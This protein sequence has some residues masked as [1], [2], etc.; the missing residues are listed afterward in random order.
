M[1]ARFHQSGS[2]ALPGCCARR[3]RTLRHAGWHIVTTPCSRAF[4]TGSHHTGPLTLKGRRDMLT[5]AILDSE[6]YACRA[7]ICT[8]RSNVSEVFRVSRCFHSITPS[9]IRTSDTRFRK[10][11]LWGVN[12]AQVIDI[13]LHRKSAQFRPIGVFGHSETGH[14]HV[15]YAPNTSQDGR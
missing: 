3:Q 7:S 15:A 6:P 9:W 10:A 11:P 5:S 14:M 4:G 8:G 1:I 12:P 13:P 2:R